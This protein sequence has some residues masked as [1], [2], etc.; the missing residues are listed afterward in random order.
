MKFLNIQKLINPSQHCFVPNKACF[1]YLLETLDTIMDALN[2]GACVDM[3]FFD[4]AKAFDKVSHT[5]SVQKLEAYGIDYVLVRWIKAFLTERKKRVMIGN[6]YSEWE[7]VIS[8]VPQGAVLGPL[9]FTF[10][11]NDLPN[12]VKNPCKLSVEDVHEIQEN[13]NRLQSWSKT[14]K[15]SF[16]YEK[17]KVM[18]FGRRNAEHEYIMELN[19]GESPHHWCSA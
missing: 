10:F 9:L 6:N 4:F 8:S 13:I 12:K 15:M 3:I 11:I 17:C 7:E 16:N 14:W 19:E 2:K 5:K 1:T 18:H